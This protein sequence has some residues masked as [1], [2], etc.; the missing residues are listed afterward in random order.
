MKLVI[1][2]GG[3]VGH[4]KLNIILQNAPD[5]EI[6]LIA[7]TINKDIEALAD[8]YPNITLLEREYDKDVLEEGEIIIVA[9]NDHSLSKKIYLD[10][11]EQG[12]LVNVADT[13]NSVILA[14]AR[15]TKG[16]FEGCHFY[17]WQIAHG[18][19]KIERNPKRCFTN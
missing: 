15:C 19:Q 14:S 9:V 7:T 17:K 13:L 8:I 12:K 18:G 16:K 10:A 5:T 3:E 4:E 11:K 6:T 1:I 2:G